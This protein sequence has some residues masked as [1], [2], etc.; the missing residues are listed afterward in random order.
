[1]DSGESLGGYRLISRLG[2]GGAGTV[3]LAED[4]GGQRVALKL[5]HPALAHSQEARARLIREAHTVNAVRSEG[6]AHVLDVEVDDTQPFIVSEFIEG[7]TLAS[8][9]QSGP[10]PPREVAD[11]AQTLS[12]VLESVHEAGIVHRDV[13]PANVIMSSRGP[14]LIDF[15][16]A[17]GEDDE[18][19]TGVGLVSGT[20]GFASPELLRGAPPTDKTDWWGWAATVLT[21]ATSRP[22]FGRGD[23]QLVLKRVFEG[24]PD[25]DGLAPEIAEAFLHALSVH[26]SARPTPMETLEIVGDMDAW[27]HDVLTEYLNVEPDEDAT[28]VFPTGETDGEA[29]SVL[30]VQSTIPP[31]EVLPQQ[32]VEEGVP[33]TQVLEVQ[34]SSLP[35]QPPMPSPTPG[36]YTAYPPPQT[37]PY[38]GPVPPGGAYNGGYVPPVP[39]PLAFPE[40]HPAPVPIIGVLM[41]AALAVLPLALGQNGLIGGAGFLLF[42]ALI[43]AFNRRLQRRRWRV[44]AERGSDIPMT[45]LALPLLLVQCII[46]LGFGIFVGTALAAGG[47]FFTQK[48][49][50]DWPGWELPLRVL[51]SQ[52]P[53]EINVLASD[54]FWVYVLWGA[55]VLVLF[56]TWILP[57]GRS[58]REGIALT[59][60][61]LLQPVWARIFLGIMLVIAIAGTLMVATTGMLEIRFF[62]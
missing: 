48:V 42:F 4:G 51:Q 32:V 12:D 56:V 1:M 53:Y 3:W 18:A 46:F 27:S 52:Y 49:R 54:S 58:L 8:R 62:M 6:V 22:P 36:G 21:A 60:R 9:L 59:A 20:A 25:I 61:G 44:G 41:M 26:P 40:R 37:P 2:V 55:F 28:M 23:A 57:S 39:M 35:P 10:L 13:K 19:L 50:D 33:P 43:G 29:T 7:P 47:W 14:I 11:L 38:P 34:P 17:R 24:E 31:T 5:I 45:L 30:P 16:I 15:G